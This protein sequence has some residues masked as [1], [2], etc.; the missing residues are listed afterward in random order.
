MKGDALQ[1]KLD[2]LTLQVRRAQAGRGPAHS[3]QRASLLRLA[4][5]ELYAACSSNPV[6]SDGPAHR[7][8]RQEI[9]RCLL[10]AERNLDGLEPRVS[11]QGCPERLRGKLLLRSR[12]MS[13]SVDLEHGGRLLELSDKHSER[14]LLELPLGRSDGQLP[15][16]CGES[17]LR[18]EAGVRGFARGK[19]PERSDLGKRRCLARV[20]RRGGALR[21]VLDCRGSLRLGGPRQALRL[22]KTVTLPARIRGLA[23]SY[24]LLNLSARPMRLLFASG[25]SFSLKDAHV[26]RMG[27][28]A[29]LSRFGLADPAARLELALAFARPARLWHFP[30]EVGTGSGRVYRG[31]RLMACWP[32]TLAPGRSWR[33]GWTLAARSWDADA[34]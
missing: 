6:S 28:V 8:L 22:T 24:R 29:G 32:V 19:E 11:R 33:V 5:Q 9:F 26:N 31:V 25:L 23:L 30:L 14:N 12:W 21:A 27:E 18:V 10:R 7:G 17:F 1:E 15:L 4:Q 20:Q 16:G 3:G 13:V 2:W 34:F